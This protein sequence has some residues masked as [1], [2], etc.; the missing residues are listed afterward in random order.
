MKFKHITVNLQKY[1]FNSLFRYPDEFPE[2]FL[3]CAKAI[4]AFQEIDGVDVCFFGMHT[5]EFGSDCLQP[6]KN[7]I[8]FNQVISELV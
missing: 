2:Q 7:R 4:L 8:S 1:C 5:Q 6:N 3:Y